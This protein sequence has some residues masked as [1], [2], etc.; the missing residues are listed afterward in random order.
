MGRTEQ[1]LA[2]FIT[3]TAA[4]DIPDESY[5]AAEQAIFDCVGVTLA[6]AAEPHGQMMTRFIATEGAQAGCS[7][8]GTGLKTSMSMAALGNGTLGHALDFDD[9]GGFGH[10]SVVLLPPALAAG[11]PAGI[12][13]R[14]LLTAYIIGFEVGYH[15]NQGSR[16]AQGERGFH[17]TAV[18]GTLAATA[19]A[20]RLLGLSTEQTIT[21]L[22][23]AGSMP[24]GIVQNFGTY[25]KP[26]H[27]GLSSRSGV[28]AALLARDG[29]TAT[30][31]VIESRVG[32]AAAYSGAGNYDAAAMVNDLGSVWGSKDKIVIKKYPCCGSNHSSL[33][34]LLSLMREHGFTLDDVAEVEAT[35][36][37]AI[38]HVL[39]YPEPTSVFQGK[40]SVHYNVATALIDGQIDIDSFAEER[41]SRPEFAEAL[42]KVDIKVSSRWDPAVSNGPTENPVTVRLKD[43]RVLTRSTNRFRMH[44][45]PV[46]PLTED[47]LTGKFRRNASLALTPDNIDAAVHAWQS[48]ADLADIRT[49]IETVAGQRIGNSTGAAI[50][51]QPSC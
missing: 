18:F 22:G 7:V 9:M 15:L 2:A 45:T 26:L 20:S 47:E 3:E 36:F 6:G 11:E 37:P 28:T 14:D 41:L 21:A 32:W 33:D 10:P 49:A 34:S 5:R 23:I 13:G 46:D 12:S 16:Y 30:D 43:G 44:G 40:F 24:S 42:D 48:I 31:N 25:T 39:L 50:P 27:A 4:N 35:G 19:V 17:A 51:A 29:W 38:S 1:R 8:I